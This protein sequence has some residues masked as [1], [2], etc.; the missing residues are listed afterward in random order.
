[1]KQS[2]REKLVADW[3]DRWHD[4]VLAILTKRLPRRADAADLAQ[5]VFL[6]LL[7]VNQLDL[8]ENPRGYLYRVAVN[9]AEEWRLQAARMP[10]V[11]DDE[12]P[13]EL[14]VAP[15]SLETWLLDEQHR[16][17]VRAAL[18]ELPL[19]VRTAIVL[20]VSKDLT[21]AQVAAHMG[22]TRRMVKRYLAKA[23]STLRER[24]IDAG[25]RQRDKTA[26]R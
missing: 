26:S 20:H 8:V 6:R 5:E 11:S 7:R 22:V 16:E 3:H 15:G 4:L 12:V 10:T 13:D 21:Y 23:H 25:V 2:D 1:M 24:M 9:I 14:F 18:M 17:V 19:A